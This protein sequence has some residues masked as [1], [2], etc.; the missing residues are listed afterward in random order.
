MRTFIFLLV[1]FVGLGSFI[2]DSDEKEF[3]C[4]YFFNDK[5]DTYKITFAITPEMVFEAKTNSTEL[6]QLV[7]KYGIRDEFREGIYCPETKIKI[8]VRNK[9]IN[10]IKVIGFRNSTTNFKA[11]LDK[12]IIIDKNYIVD[13]KKVL[14]YVMA[15]L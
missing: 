3:N 4:W 14:E 6:Q 1:A 2:Q 7:L 10:G 12:P 11:I 15:N 13:K 8:L 9:K 5:S